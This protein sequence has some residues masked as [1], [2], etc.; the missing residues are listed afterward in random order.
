MTLPAILALEKTS[1]ASRRRILAG[2]QRGDEQAFADTLQ[3]TH[4]TGALAEVRHLA[5]QEVE[6]A[7][8]ALQN[9]RPMISEIH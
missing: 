1:V 4:E 9:F 5:V 8:A 3:L 7:M 2:W 6:Q